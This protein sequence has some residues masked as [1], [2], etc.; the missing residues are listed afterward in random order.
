MLVTVREADLRPARPEGNASREYRAGRKTQRLATAGT[1]NMLTRKQ[2]FALD[3]IRHGSVD[4]YVKRMGW[5]RFSVYL[6][7]GR[8]DV[9]TQVKSLLRKKLICYDWSSDCKLVL[10]KLGAAAM[11]DES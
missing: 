10:T 3:C 6:V 2:W 5:R 8:T 4:H 11:M 7:R 1:N 9:T